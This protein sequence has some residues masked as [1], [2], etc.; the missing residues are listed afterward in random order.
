MTLFH[1]AASGTLFANRT[2]VG[3]ASRTKH[4]G[5]FGGIESQ[6]GFEGIVKGGI[7]VF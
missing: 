4:D 7:D 6:L 3:T 2:M 1:A 5:W